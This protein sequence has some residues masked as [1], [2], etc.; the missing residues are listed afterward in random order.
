MCTLSH[1]H[2]RN[3]YRLRALCVDA[4]ASE[5]VHAPSSEETPP[6]EP[7]LRRAGLCMALLMILYT[8]GASMV[9]TWMH[10]AKSR[11][12]DDGSRNKASVHSSHLPCL[13]NGNEVTVRACISC[14]G[15][16]AIDIRVCVYICQNVHTWITA[17]RTS[18]SSSPR[19]WRRD[20]TASS[21]E[22]ESSVLFISLPNLVFQP[23]SMP[24]APSACAI[25][26]RFS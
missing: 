12:Y 17:S 14:A 23:W 2:A 19:R 24:T 15:I 16:R 25:V 8:A 6:T 13:F 20:F 5:A 3:V 10:T 9:Y 11:R 21:S 18:K 22:G 26:I 1:T 7:A 4:R